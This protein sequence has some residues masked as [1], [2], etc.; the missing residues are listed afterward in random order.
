MSSLEIR[1]ERVV[2]PGGI[3]PAT[4]RIVD[5]VITGVSS[6]GNT[7][8]G[9]DVMN[10]GQLVVLPGLVDSHVHINEP[11]RTDWEGFEHATRAAAAGGTTTLVDMPLNSIPPTTTGAGFAAKLAAAT[12]HCHVDVGFWGGLVPGNHNDLAPLADAGVLG[13]KSFLSPSGVAEFENVS[14]QDLRTSLPELAKL[15]LPLLVHAE[16]PSLLEDP[17]AN[18]S[19]VSDPRRYDTPEPVYKRLS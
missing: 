7:T 1:S 8:A 16:L 15:D 17:R 18:A 9:V 19:H 10:V 11:G 5:G 12:G 13:F 4:I 6:H 3:R 14:E 2:T